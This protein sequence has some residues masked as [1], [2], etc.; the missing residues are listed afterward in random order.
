MQKL[1]ILTSIFNYIAEYNNNAKTDFAIDSI[2]IEFSKQH[3][4]DKLKTLGVWRKV[5]SCAKVSSALKHKLKKRINQDQLTSAMYLNSH[6]VYYNQ[7]DKPKYRLANFVAFG[8]KQYNQ[9][10]SVKPFDFSLV[11]A[12]VTILKPDT[13]K[14]DICIDFTSTPNIM[15]LKKIFIIDEVA[16]TRGITYYCNNP[17]IMSIDKFYCYDKAL[18]NTLQSTLWRLEAQ[19]SISNPKELYMPLNELMDIYE[20]LTKGT[21]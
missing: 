3:K 8:L 15:E 2:K 16:S 19:I 6:I 12:I 17:N 21:K 4:L 7:L 14:I 5:R 18:K 11:D 9:D 13:L 20:I 1:S 10:M